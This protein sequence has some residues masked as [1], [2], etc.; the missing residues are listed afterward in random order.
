MKFRFAQSGVDIKS[1]AEKP[2]KS[3]VI[4]QP[5]NEIINQV[6]LDQ[7]CNPYN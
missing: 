2:L 1:V 5:V 6:A 7:I 4:F 3:M